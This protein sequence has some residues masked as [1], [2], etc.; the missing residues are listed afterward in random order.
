MWR[1]PVR[2]NGSQRAALAKGPLAGAGQFGVSVFDSAKRV[3]RSDVLR[4]FDRPGDG[5]Y[6]MST[7]GAV[8]VRG[9]D[10]AILAGALGEHLARL[11]TLV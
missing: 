10:V 2:V 3:H 11:S 1:V 9:A 4:W 7:D 8:T 6:L 5:R